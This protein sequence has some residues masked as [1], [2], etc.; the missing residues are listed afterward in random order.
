MKSW[1]NSDCFF[2][3]N[4]KLSLLFLATSVHLVSDTRMLDQDLVA[5]RSYEKMKSSNET[6]PDEIQ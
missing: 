4:C 1:L 2:D 3:K 5:T 6:L